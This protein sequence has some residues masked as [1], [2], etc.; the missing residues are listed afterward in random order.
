MVD[1]K[2]YK[3]ETV[4]VTYANGMKDVLPLAKEQIE[5]RDVMGELDI[6]SSFDKLQISRHFRMSVCPTCS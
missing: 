1:K 4:S 5:T 3:G 2:S 6:H